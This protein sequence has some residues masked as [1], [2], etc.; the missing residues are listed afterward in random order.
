MPTTVTM[1]EVKTGAMTVVSLT[2]VRVN[3]GID[4]S[5]FS[6]RMLLRG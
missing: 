5:V 3:V 6:R 1:M 4:D 2:G